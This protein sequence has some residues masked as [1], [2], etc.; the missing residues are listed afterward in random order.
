MTH[1]DVQAWLDRY[2]EAWRSY[3]GAAV[4]ALFAEDAEYRFQP[5]GKPL[6]GR[7]AI[8]ENWLNP[9]GSADKRDAPGTWVAHYE[10]F[11]V[12]G[13]RAVAIGETTYFRDASQAA[14][15]HRYWNGWLLEFDDAGQCRSFVESYME[16]KRPAS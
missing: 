8:V 5:W 1:A 14:I 4:A 2:V 16:R 12:D 11:A 13:Q 10:P 3:D 6:R 9:S 15:E 7:A